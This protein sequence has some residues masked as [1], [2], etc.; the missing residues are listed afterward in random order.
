MICNAYKD[1]GVNVTVAEV[2]KANGIAEGGGV[3]AGQKL[4]IPKPGT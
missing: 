1:N 3:K 4:F 2:R